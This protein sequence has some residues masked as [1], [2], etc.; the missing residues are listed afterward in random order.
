MGEEDEECGERWLWHE[1]I[2]WAMMAFPFLSS[3]ILSLL[4]HLE[5]APLEYAVRVMEEGAEMGH[6]QHSLPSQ[7]VHL[8]GLPFQQLDMKS[9]GRGTSPFVW[10]QD[11]VKETVAALA[12]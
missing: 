4:P 2:Y 7:A 8:R 10:D 3:L 11:K 1:A 9:T 5:L 6:I 12:S